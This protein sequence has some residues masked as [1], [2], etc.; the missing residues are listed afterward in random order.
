MARRT[1]AGR[2]QPEEG[3]ATEARA[4]A[5]RAVSLSALKE[6]A[7]GLRRAQ[8]M[9]GLSHVI[10]LPDGSFESWSETLPALLRIQPGQIVPSTRKWLELVHPADRGR[11]RDVALRARADGR[12]A[13]IEYR[14]WRSDGSWIHVRQVMEPIPGEPDAQG[15]L[16]WFNTIQDITAQ[17]DDADRI[18]RLNRMYA[19]LSEVHG[20]MVR[21]R[22]RA[23]LFKEACEIL[24]REGGLRMAWLGLAHEDGTRVTAVASAGEVGD[25]FQNAPMSLQEGAPDFGFIGQVMR[26]RTA[27]SSTDVHRDPRVAMKKEFLARGINSMAIIPLVSGTRAVGVLTLHHSDPGHFDEAEMRLVSE[28]AG[29]VVY[30]MEYLEKSE[31]ADYLAYYDPVTSLANRTLF[32]ERLA[33]AINAAIEQKQKMALLLVDIER[34]K[35]INDTLGRQ[36]GDLLLKR[37]A[38]RMTTLV[39]HVRASRIGADQFAIVV[40]DFPSEQ[41]LARRIEG[42]MKDFFGLAYPLGDTELRISGRMG[43]AVAPE[44]GS[45][46]DTLFHNAEAALK[47]AKQAGDAYVFYEQRMSERV[48]ERLSLENKLRRALEREEFVLHYQPKVDMAS[49]RIV[50]VE[51]LLRWKDPGGGLVPPG[52]FIPLLE[53][54]GLILPVGTWALARAAADHLAWRRAGLPAPRIAVNVSPIQLRQRGFVAMVEEAVRGPDGIGGVDLEVTENLLMDDIQ[55][56]IGKL[57][58]VRDLGLEV[59]I[60]DFGTGYSSLAYLAK[61]PAQTLKIDRSFILPLSHEPD[62]MT[63]V[64]TMIS[65]AHSLRLKVVAGGVETEDQAKILRL[66]RC[67]E[68]QG[69][70]FSRPVPQEDLLRLLSA[71]PR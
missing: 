4:T 48:S 20:L 28:L 61:L 60:D 36:A 37:V 50:G 66:V 5:R 3:A 63:L 39:P 43:I 58:A 34:F 14:L 26:D 38:E 23:V 2:P 41:E 62:A 55:S 11:F 49:A 31:K 18:R 51:A 46:A 70:L 25:F 44:D 71:P 68:M 64:S 59:A 69:F 47:K 24:V 1:A 67:D 19:V 42:R 57:K 13:D 6:Q 10:T 40:S 22:T 52:Q 7:A 65:L 16:R 27:A 33:Q 15:R 35:T 17:K 53:E 29:A 12:R 45:N 54:T 30:A 9:A 56:N 21:V 8:A 32:H